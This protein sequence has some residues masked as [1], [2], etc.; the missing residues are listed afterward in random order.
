[1]SRRSLIRAAR[2]AALSLG[3]PQ[4]AQYLIS[5]LIVAQSLARSR[6]VHR[7]RPEPPRVVAPGGCHNS[8]RQAQSIHQLIDSRIARELHGIQRS[9]PEPR[10]EAVAL[11]L[12]FLHPLEGLV[13]LSPH[14]V[15]G[16]EA[17]RLDILMSRSLFQAFEE[18]FGDLPVTEPGWT[19]TAFETHTATPPE[20]STP[21]STSAIASA[22]LPFS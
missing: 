22:I 8:S 12:G 2:L 7:R 14:P 20:S 11:L 21:L 17:I 10:Q 18:A 16:D 9:D 19:S 4:V 13:R 1:M 15:D 3:L 6:S 5:I